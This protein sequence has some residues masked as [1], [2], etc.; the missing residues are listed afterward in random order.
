MATNTQLTHLLKGRT[1]DSVRQREC[2]F[3]I[4]FTDGWTLSIVLATYNQSVKLTN[5]DDKVEYSG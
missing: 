3:D 5:D 1:V 2:G 4:D